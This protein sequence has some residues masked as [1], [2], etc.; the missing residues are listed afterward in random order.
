MSNGGMMA[1]RFAAERSERIAAAAVVS[2]T[3]GGKPSA[4]KRPW[5][6]PAPKRSVPVIVFHGA[7][8]KKIPYHGGPDPTT[9]TGR[10]HA[11]VAASVG[12]WV[13]HNGCLPEPRVDRLSSE[14]ILRKTWVSKR[15]S[16]CV[17]LYSLQE[18]GHVWPGPHVTVDHPW[19]AVPDFDA[20]E[21]IWEFFKKAGG[22]SE[23]K[24]RFRE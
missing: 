9:R 10:T 12:F 22:R 17:V 20:A 7:E 4:G 11:S 16:P 13:R 6:P 18:W 19:E 15:A 14:R 23:G 8:D 24:G 21:I 5:H 1:Y 2:G 3:I